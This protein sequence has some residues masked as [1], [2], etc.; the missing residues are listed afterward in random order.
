MYLNG[1]DLLS[2]FC[3]KNK[4]PTPTIKSLKK[5]SEDR[6][7]R[8]YYNLNACAFYHDIS[9]SK[10]TLPPQTICIM[11]PKCAAIGYS[12]R[13]WS[14]PGYCIDRTPYG[15]L[16]HELGHHVDHLKSRASNSHYAKA[17]YYEAQKEDPLTGYL[18]KGRPHNGSVVAEWFAE[19]F[20]LFVTNPDFLCKLRPR[21]YEAIKEDFK[22]IETRS[23]EEVLSEAPERT[24]EQARKKV[25]SSS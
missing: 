24:K 7:E 6:V 20:R 8:L 1:I 11:L 2:R 12:A 3:Q 15:V 4:I 14:Y 18:G 23:W 16:Q 19:M 10:E 9:L 5:D 17:I 22:P 25:D 13:F 21:T